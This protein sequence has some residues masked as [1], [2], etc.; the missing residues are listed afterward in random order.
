MKK[1]MRDDF[2]KPLLCSIHFIHTGRN[3][4][5]DWDLFTISYDNSESI[6]ESGTKNYVIL[7]S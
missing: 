7:P 3:V 6:Q 1:K 4:L 2:R 5:G